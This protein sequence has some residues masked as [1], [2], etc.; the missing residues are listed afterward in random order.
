MGMMNKEE[1][2]D[3]LYRLRSEIYVY[4]P[5]EWLIPMNNALDMT[6]K[7]LEQE[8]CEDCV[9]RA[10]VE[11]FLD[12]YNFVSYD[13]TVEDLVKA[14]PSVYPKTK[15]G[16]WIPVS[17]R[18]PKAFEFVNCTCHSLI[19]DRE[20]WVVETVYIP[21]LPDSP[22]S[23]WGNIPMLNCGDCEVVAWM[24]RDIPKP[25]KAESEGNNVDIQTEC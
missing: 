8:P 18:L 12:K 4:M 6:I 10:D 5:K 7:A 13:Y 19:D 25:Y 23:D 11:T 14:L 2:L 3:W 1:T 21:Q 16:K 17:E 15:V 9:S 20:D 22:Y 24:Y